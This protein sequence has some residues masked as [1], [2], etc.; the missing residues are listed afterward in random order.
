MAALRVWQQRGSLSALRPM[1]LLRRC[2]VP[3]ASDLYGGLRLR[4]ALLRYASGFEL[5]IS[6]TSYT[7]AFSLGM[8]LLNRG[9]ANSDACQDSQCY[10]GMRLRN[11]HAVGAA[12]GWLA[13]LLFANSST[14]PPEYYSLFIA[15]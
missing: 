1:R 8:Q 9:G 2:N 7:G 6:A 11:A 10:Y 4:K 5:S 13:I 14:C 12:S 15:I 3:A